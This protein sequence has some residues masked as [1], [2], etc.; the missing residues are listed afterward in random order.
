MFRGCS[1]DV[2]STVRFLAMA[3]K[4]LPAAVHSRQSCVR[5]SIPIFAGKP[6]MIWNLAK[7]NK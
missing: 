3:V 6:E 2:A 5:A 7:E 1:T 4:Q